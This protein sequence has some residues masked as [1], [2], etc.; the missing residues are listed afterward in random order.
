M[1]MFKIAHTVKSTAVTR[2]DV[3]AIV[4]AGALGGVELVLGGMFIYEQFTR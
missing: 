4:L 3:L 2:E 1:V